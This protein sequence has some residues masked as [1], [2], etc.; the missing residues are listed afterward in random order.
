MRK[1][2]RI[3]WI[4]IS[5]TLLVTLYGYRLYEV[6]TKFVLDPPVL[7]YEAGVPVPL[8][9][10]EAV[11]LEHRIME[12][13]EGLSPEEG[14]DYAV[15]DLSLTNNGEEPIQQA[16]TSYILYNK[17]K[18]FALDY[19]VHL[20]LKEKGNFSENIIAPGQTVNGKLVYQIPEGMKEMYLKYPSREIEKDTLLFL[21]ESILRF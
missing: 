13:M 16:I 9:S 8:G 1:K 19:D 7:Q 14:Y 12:Q 11:L 4:V 20:K 21:R 3:W 5:I 10:L 17:F 15:L 18:V 6:N 2:R